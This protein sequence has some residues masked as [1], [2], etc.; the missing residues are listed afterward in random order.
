MNRTRQQRIG[1][2]F[3]VLPSV[4]MVV[5]GALEGLWIAVVLGGVAGLLGVTLYVGIGRYE[6]ELEQFYATQI[7]YA[8]PPAFAYTLSQTVAFT[9]AFCCALYVALTFDLVAPV[10]EWVPATDSLVVLGGAVLGL[11]L[12]AGYPPLMQR[13]DLVPLLSVGRWASEL[14]GGL[15]V[16]AYAVLLFGS[17]PL[18]G[19]V[20]G[21]TYVGSRIA[22]LGGIRASARTDRNSA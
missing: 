8:S 4:F 22:V 14:D 17:D 10:S 1:S 13:Q 15:F 3:L 11:A 20:F 6:T 9:V 2:V 21:V 5:V 7:D 18:S 19:V 16:T 12:G